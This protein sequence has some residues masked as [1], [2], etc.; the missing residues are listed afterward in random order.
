METKKKL[1]KN[2]N[3]VRSEP[4]KTGTRSANVEEL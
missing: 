1:Y 3:S 2:C 4:M